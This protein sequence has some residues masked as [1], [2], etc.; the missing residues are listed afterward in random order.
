MKRLSIRSLAL[1][2]ML[3]GAV[4]L[5]PAAF[6]EDGEGAGDDLKKKIRAKLE[7]ILKLMRDN[8][9]ALLKLSTGT[10]AKTRKVE[11]DVPEGQPQ[12]GEAG[13]GDAGSK[14]GPSG[15][16]AV[17]EI[18]KLLESVSKKGGSIPDELKQLVEMIPL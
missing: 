14:S 13:K 16:S 15:E 18:K 2:V 12:G 7:K 11:V 6:A 8:E 17:E 5:S 9:A 3:A 10:A 1:L 4:L